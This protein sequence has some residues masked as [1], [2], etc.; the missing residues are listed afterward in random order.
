MGLLED[1]IG[2]VLNPKTRGGTQAAP[3][4]SGMSPMMM[5]MLAYLAYRALAGQKGGTPQPAPQPSPGDMGDVLREARRG[6]APAPQPDAGAGG[7]LGDIL[8]DILGG[9]QPGAPAPGGARVPGGQASGGLGDILGDILGGGRAGSASSGGGPGNSGLD[10][11]SDIIERF[12][13]SGQ[14]DAA[15]SWVG[16]GENK[17]VSPGEMSA[18]LDADTLEQLQ[19]ATGLDR[20][21]LLAG[22]AQT[23]PGVV[24]QL[25]PDGRLPTPQEWQRAERE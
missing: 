2:G 17:P 12:D 16:R 20:D 9:G 3:G 22:L 25:T 13:K 8:G 23:L 10:E 15:R 5:A 24:D 7:G 14:G 11:L 4:R 1:V 19:G 21:E 6:G 18:V